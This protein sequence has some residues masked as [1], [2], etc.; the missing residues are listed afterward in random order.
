MNKKLL[1]AALF[2]ASTTGAFA[3]S[4]FEGA[5]GQVGIGY[6][7]VSPK[8]SNGSLTAAGTTYPYTTSISSSNSFTG[9]VGLG[10]TFAI[11]KDY[12]LG[13]GAEYS[14][15]E[16]SSANYTYSNPN[17]GSA[18]GSY[19]KTSSYNV[20]LSPGVVVNKDGLAYAKIG[21][22]GAT[23]KDTEGSTSTNTNYTGYSLGLGYKQ[24]IQG[25]LYGFGEVNYMSY[26]NQTSNTSGTTGGTAYKTT[27]T[28]S[29]NAFNAVVGIGY[30]F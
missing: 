3:Q 6:E 28:S 10:Y 23:I 5:Y 7:N 8:L 1:V 17:L 26:G 30:K 24:I 14:P 12:T 22:T 25:G 2:A 15:I 21:F 9:N 13:I 16:G 20:F 27:L 11:N 29:A 19:K 18:T 4:A